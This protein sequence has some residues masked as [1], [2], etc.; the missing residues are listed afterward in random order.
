[1]SKPPAGLVV[2]GITV[3]TCA[4]VLLLHASNASHTQPAAT[5]PA[6]KPHARS[7]ANSRQTPEPESNKAPRGGR[8]KPAPQ[9]TKPEK[10]P[11]DAPSAADVANLRGK[12]A[13]FLRAY[14]LVKPKDTEAVRRRRVGRLAPASVLD[15][16]DLGLSTGTPADTARIHLRLTQRGTP[17]MPRMK[18]TPATDEPIDKLVKVPVVI[19]VKKPD[20]TEVSHSA[21]NTVAWW[22]YKNGGWVIQSFPEPRR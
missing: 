21:V 15:T 8:R 3:T 4:A 17:A 20:G 22:E 13:E 1:M 10:K 6:G 16:L 9:G 14:Y 5:T 2:V 12:S 19:T 7:L 11:D 18:I